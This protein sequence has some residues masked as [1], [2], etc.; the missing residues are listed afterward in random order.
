MTAPLI[1]KVTNPR[2]LKKSQ[3]KQDVVMVN[4][5]MKKAMKSGYWSEKPGQKAIKDYHTGMAQL[6][7]RLLKVII[8]NT[9]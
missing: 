1:P 4:V 3:N 5:G 2:I 8:P 9:C 6:D 7:Q